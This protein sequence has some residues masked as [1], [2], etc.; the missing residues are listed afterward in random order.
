[1]EVGFNQSSFL[2]TE[3]QSG[4]TNVCVEIRSGILERNISVYLET[5]DGNIDMIDGG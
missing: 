5:L 2:A 3:E 4:T 1:M